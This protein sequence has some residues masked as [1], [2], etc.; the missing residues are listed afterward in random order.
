MENK[1]DKILSLPVSI[2]IATLILAALG[3]TMKDWG[4][5]MIHQ[6]QFDKFT[7]NNPK[8]E[9]EQKVLPS[10]GVELPISWNDLGK[11]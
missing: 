7:A 8:T 6:K 3:C 5:L 11:N 9:L 10:E 1:L 4:L 2:I